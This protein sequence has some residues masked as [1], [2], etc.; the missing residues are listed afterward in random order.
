MLPI[1]YESPATPAVRDLAQ[2]IERVIEE[3]HRSHPNL[4]PREVTQALRLAEGTRVTRRAGRRAAL[5]MIGGAVAAG[6]AL[7]GTLPERG[8]GTGALPAVVA[9]GLLVIFLLV[10]IRLRS[11]S[12]E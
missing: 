9:V 10:M 8:G 3:F 4:K 1:Q 6:A 5:A 7:L 11:S 2:R 12:E